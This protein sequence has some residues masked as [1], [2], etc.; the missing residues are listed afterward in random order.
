M[1]LKGQASMFL[2]QRV[3][4]L[5]FYAVALFLFTFSQE[6]GQGYFPGGT[7]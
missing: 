5:I 7:P 2:T 1:A 3:F 4:A 6:I